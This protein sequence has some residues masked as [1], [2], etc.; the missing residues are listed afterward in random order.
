MQ[1]RGGR[2]TLGTQ[3]VAFTAGRMGLAVA[4]DLGGLCFGGGGVRGYT[5]TRLPAHMQNS[6]CPAN[7]LW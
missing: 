3:P 1:L 7:T 6:Y 4:I 2:Q 5:C